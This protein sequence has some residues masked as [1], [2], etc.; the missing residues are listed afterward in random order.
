MVIQWSRLQGLPVLPERPRSFD[1]T[2]YNAN[3]LFGNSIDEL[4]ETFTDYR[5]IISNRLP[6][7]NPGTHDNDGVQYANGYGKQSSAVIVPAFLAA[8]TGKDPNTFDLD[9]ERRV[10]RRTYIP[11]PNWSLRYD[12][13]S[14]IPWFKDRFQSFTLE[15]A[16]TSVLR[17]SN[18]NTD[19][20]YDG[21]FQEKRQNGNYY[22]R[23]EIPAVQ[24]TEAFNPLVGLKMK[25]KSDFTL[26]FEYSKSRDLNL[27]INTSSQLEEDKKETF[28]FGVG[29]T[30]K[31]SDFLKKKK[32]RRPSTRKTR[33]DSD[34]D[35]SVKDKVKKKVTSSR[36]SDMTF[37]LNFSYNDNGFFVHQIDKQ[38]S[39]ED[40]EV[41]GEKGFQIN[42]TVDY[43]LNETIT[44][45]A[46]FDY[47]MSTPYGISNF[48]R[49]N[50]AGGINVRMTLK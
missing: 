24:I 9:L 30:I 5:S 45:R 10:S 23:V 4:F 46:F 38:V 8:Y 1:M 7:P 44:L 37:M 49:T 41:R 35:D 6:N 50:I 15:H 11:K 47:N 19:V 39:V 42:P 48:P 12:G 25:T 40:N 33:D 21:L 31:D 43:I 16:Y 34:D 3:T 32:G 13:L 28:T 26:E 29:Y 36:G 17:V 27:K 2:F 20:Q 22:T 14:K 18:F